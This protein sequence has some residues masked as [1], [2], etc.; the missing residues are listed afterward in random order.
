MGKGRCLC[1]GKAEE[2]MHGIGGKGEGRKME[3]EK[4]GKGQKAQMQKFKRERERER[5][6]I[7]QPPP[8]SRPFSTAHMAKG[9]ACQTRLP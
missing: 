6:W 4:R 5:D 8:L 1:S 9:H 7:T 2:G 3:R